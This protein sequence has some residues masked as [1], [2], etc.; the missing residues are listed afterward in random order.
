MFLGLGTPSGLWQSVIM[1]PPN[2]KSV[3]PLVPIKTIDGF[4]DKVQHGPFVIFNAE[5][6]RRDDLLYS[7]EY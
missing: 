5:T 4:K 6:E 1:K 2:V 7:S 3:Y